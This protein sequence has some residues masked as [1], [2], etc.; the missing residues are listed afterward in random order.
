MN[1]ELLKRPSTIIPLAASL[2]SLAM[3]L[4][5]AAMYGVTHETDEGTA[6]HVFQLLMA[7]QLPVIAYFTLKWLPE[8]P[9]Q[10]LLILAMHAV[11]ASAAMVAVVLLT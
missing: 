5:H 3:V 9:K 1:M 10:A 7:A 2:T 4:V 8:A 11:A 6:A